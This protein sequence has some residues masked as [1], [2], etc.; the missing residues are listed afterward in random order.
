[1]LGT[2]FGRLVKI[3]PKLGLIFESGSGARN[4]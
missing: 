3:E 1:M 2:W 4:E